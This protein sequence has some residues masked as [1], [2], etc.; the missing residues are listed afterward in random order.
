ME[1][2]RAFLG[3]RYD[4]L[5]ESS[6]RRLTKNPLRILDSKDSG[7]QAILGDSPDLTRYLD[8]E[9]QRQFDCLLGHLERAGVEYHVNSRLVRGLDYYTGA[10]YEWT[11]SSLGAQDAFC[12]GGRYDGLVAQLGGSVVPAAGFACGMERLVELYSQ[13]RST[14]ETVGAEVWMIMLG[15]DAEAIGYPLAENLREAGIQVVCNCGGGSIGKQLRR[16]DKSHA[17]FAV[18]IGGEELANR[19]FTVKS[20][21]SGEEQVSM[22]EDS[23]VDF[24]LT[25]R[26]REHSAL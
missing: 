5:D 12:G 1:D 24:F 17:L 7:T 2:L 25:Q 18:I 20:L 10:V 22:T 16:A 6:R 3:S 11:S 4:E 15:D 26:N 14:T 21:R 23:L 8:N 19:R 9:D 13:Q